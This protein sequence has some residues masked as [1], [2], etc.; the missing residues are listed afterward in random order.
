MSWVLLV[1]EFPFCVLMYK[2]PWILYST[3]KTRKIFRVCFGHFILDKEYTISQHTQMLSNTV[4]LWRRFSQVI[5]HYYLSKFRNLSVLFKIFYL[6][7]H[8]KKLFWHCN[9]LCSLKWL[10]LVLAL[11]SVIL[12]QNWS[13][14]Y[15]VYHISY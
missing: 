6:I 7:N 3:E 2:K 15:C 5:T 4:T 13:L 10:L 8:I 12:A 11:S 14:S 9:D 1:T